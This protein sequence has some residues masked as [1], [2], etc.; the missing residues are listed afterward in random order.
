[1][2]KSAD[3]SFKHFKSEQMARALALWNAYQNEQGAKRYKF[4][5]GRVQRG[6]DS[7]I[8]LHLEGEPMT[9][10]EECKKLPAKAG[11]YCETCKDLPL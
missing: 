11:K 8:A 3:G 5:E 4:C 2:K 6:A 7:L 1:M 9:M 10:C